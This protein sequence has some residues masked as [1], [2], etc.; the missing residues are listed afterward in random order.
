MSAI[1]W[2]SD[3]YERKKSLKKGIGVLTT[4]TDLRLVNDY[5]R[6]LSFDEVL[7]WAYRVTDF[8]RSLMPVTSFG[9]TGLVILHRMRQ[10]G[11]LQKVVTIDTL[12]LFPETYS[13]IKS[14]ENDLPSAIQLL[15]YKPQ[16]IENL[17][18]FNDTYGVDLY[19]TNPEQYAYL[20]KVEPLHRALDENDVKI[21]ITGRRQDQGGERSVIEILEIDESSL[22]KPR[23]KL[24]P[25]AYWSRDRVSSYISMNN[26]SYNKLYDQGYTS[27]GDIMTTTKPNNGK[28][29]G[30]RFDKGDGGCKEC[31]IHSKLVIE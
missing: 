31:G 10:L 28:E 30:G 18:K 14:W 12:H 23:W 2:I 4:T 27:I 3:S 20:S 9:L 29:R 22:P 8:G 6:E 13:F 1:P 7:Q 5:L 25:L 26:I 16:G 19:K 17:Q 11:L 15:V 21:W 24:N